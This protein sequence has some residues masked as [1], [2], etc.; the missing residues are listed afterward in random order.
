M[1]KPA[2]TWP[3]HLNLYWIMSILNKSHQSRSNLSPN[4]I[5]S[6]ST[7]SSN[8]GQNHNNLEQIISILTKWS[9]PRPNQVHLDRIISTIESSHIM[10]KSIIL[11]ILIKRYQFR[12]DRIILMQFISISTETNFSIDHPRPNR[13]NICQRI[14]VWAI[15]T[16]SSQIRLNT[17]SI[18]WIISMPT[19]SFRCPQ[20]HLNVDRIIYISTKSSESRQKT[21]KSFPTN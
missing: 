3:N 13:L 2:Q 17:F 15:S 9:Q 20:N 7:E 6:I 10:T 8:L 1:T 11:Y 18:E 12:V 14:P 16:K 19:E 21:H 4:Q 5:V